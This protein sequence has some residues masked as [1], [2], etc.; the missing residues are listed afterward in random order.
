MTKSPCAT[1]GIGSLEECPFNA[2]ADPFND[3]CDATK[4][5]WVNV[6]TKSLGADCENTI[7]QHCKSNFRDDESG[8]LDFIEILLGGNTC[9]Y[10]RLPK[11]AMDALAEGVTLGRGGK[12]IVYVF[13][14]GNSFYKGE[15]V[16]FSRWPNSRYTIAVGAVGKD[17]F[18]ADYSTPGAALHVVGPAGDADD[19]GHIMT[20]GLDN[21]CR[22][23]GK[24][25]SFSSPVV[26]GV[27]AL[28]LEARPELTW[29]DVQGIL[30]ETSSVK[31][32]PKDTTKTT[33]AA[34]KTHSNWYG[35]GLV[36]AKKAV[37][38]AKTWTLL[39]PEYQAIGAS[40]EE[41]Q[42]IPNNGTEYVSELTMSDDYTGFTAESS[43]VMLNLQHYNRGDLELTLVSPG[44]TES[45]LHPGRRL[46][47][48]QL[49][50]DERWKLMTV[51][52]W[53]E[54][55]AGT[56][57]LKIK[58]L[59]TGNT[60]TDGAN[61]L[62]QWKLIVYGQTVDG[63]PPVLTMVSE[64][65][66]ETPTLEA[67]SM[68]P[69]FN[70]TSPGNST[71][72]EPS[73]F[74]TNTTE[75]PTEAPTRPEPPAPSSTPT[76]APT[77]TPGRKTMPPLM[78]IRPTVLVQ[79]ATPQ[80][81]LPISVVGAPRGIPAGG[82]LPQFSSQTV[83]VGPPGLSATLGGAANRPVVV[84][85]TVELSAQQPD[86]R[87]GIVS[88]FQRFGGDEEET[89][90][91]YL[92]IELVPNLSLVLW[93]ISEDIPEENWE[94]IETALH[95][96]TMAVVERE[97]PELHFWAEVEL[98]SVTVNDPAPHFH[99]RSLQPDGEL[100]PSVTIFYDVLI[101]FDHVPGEEGLK[102]TTLAAL[103]FAD[104]EDRNAFVKMIHDQH[105]QLDQENPW[106]QPLQSVSDLVYHPVD[107]PVSTQN[108]LVTTIVWLVGA[109]TLCISLA[110]T[111]HRRR[112]LQQ[113]GKDHALSNTI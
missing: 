14:S 1:S 41:N 8:C 50:G 52:N 18:H 58:D 27:I 7:F 46:E 105:N 80:Q 12:G 96:H 23:S 33:N 65:P 84:V 2:E 81:T 104:P 54:D 53:G 111:F 13:A 68:A 5:D 42:P 43:V 63:L 19:A 100:I 4:C 60:V 10:D 92:S 88:N 55:P 24:G 70:G 86:P 35:F 87:A 39:T 20:T 32:D 48:N 93:G 106:L 94:P 17:G 6:G 36:D 69:S 26:S 57:S 49:E 67:T 9:N 62:R 64:S 107:E 40:A 29:R 112:R 90:E 83:P 75:I 31:T 61:E 30:V 89:A 95:E 45:I 97:M 37:D 82:T 85:S 109:G 74:E 99:K 25:T 108:N 98:A 22:N 11:D 72:E 91:Q 38:L 15:D 3:P 79:G 66:S 77:L 102:G 47:N 103:P 76:Q 113:G 34:G 56:W 110:V 16:N 73:D 59:E 28:M 101:H 44:G 21:T 71:E 51:R 78:M